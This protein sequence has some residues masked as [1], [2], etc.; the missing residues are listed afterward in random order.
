MLIYFDRMYE[1]DGHTQIDRQT[2][3]D[4]HRMT[5][6]PALA[7]HLVAKTTLRFKNN[8]IILPSCVSPKKI[9]HIGEGT[10]ILNI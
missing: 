1:R 2:H 9:T 8:T 7:K 3:T 10:L 4:R 5:A 6:Y